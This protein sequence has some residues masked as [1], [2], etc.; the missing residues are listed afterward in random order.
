MATLGTGISDG[1]SNGLV[2]GPGEG[3]CDGSDVLNPE[4]ATVESKV[5]EEVV[6]F[7]VMMVGDRV[8]LADGEGTGPSIGATADG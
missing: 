6:T 4:V 5:G 1:S 7:S 8:R 2:L 3:T